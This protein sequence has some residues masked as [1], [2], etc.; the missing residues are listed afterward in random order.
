MLDTLLEAFAGKKGVWR[1]EGA[2]LRNIF[3][4]GDLMA[5]VEGALAKA[6]FKIELW[7]DEE[8]RL[9]KIE[10]KTTSEQEDTIDWNFIRYV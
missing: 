1:K 5:K 8:H 9:W 3:Q 2:T 10:K 6:D 4:D 7:T